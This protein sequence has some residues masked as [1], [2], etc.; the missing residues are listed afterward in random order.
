MFN[1]FFICAITASMKNVLNSYLYQSL[2]NFFH[3]LKALLGWG[4]PAKQQF[5]RKVINGLLFAQTL[6]PFGLLLFINFIAIV[7]LF[8]CQQRKP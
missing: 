3:P 2:T 1:A 4:P 6:V 5:T 8:P 7:A